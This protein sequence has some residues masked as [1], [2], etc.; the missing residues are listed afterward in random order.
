[1]WC[2]CVT[3]YNAVEFGAFVALRPAHRA[4]GLSGTELSEV[5]GRLGNDIFVELEG[6]AAK[7]FTC[8]CVST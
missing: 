2:E 5:L 3:N 7:R 4:L 6:D 1:M 8:K